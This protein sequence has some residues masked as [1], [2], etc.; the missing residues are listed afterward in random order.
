MQCRNSIGLTND[1]YMMRSDEMSDRCLKTIAQASTIPCLRLLPH[2]FWSVP[3]RF[4][5]FDNQ[6]LFDISAQTFCNTIYQL[7]H[8][9]GMPS[10]NALFASPDSLLYNTSNRTTYRYSINWSMVVVVDVC[11]GKNVSE[12]ASSANHYLTIWRRFTSID[13]I[14]FGH[15]RNKLVAAC[16]VS[17]YVLNQI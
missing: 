17:V 5:P 11:G 15:L 14:V 6:N 3:F 2:D 16:A 4:V 9:S 12:N 13:L 7:S 8:W 1:Y 10:S